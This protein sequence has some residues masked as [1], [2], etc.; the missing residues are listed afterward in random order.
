M[1]D[2]IYRDGWLHSV[3]E[4][5]LIP[6]GIVT[7][8]LE[9]GAEEV[10]IVS[11]FDTLFKRFNKEEIDYD[12]PAVLPTSIAE[13]YKPKEYSA[14]FFS[15]YYPKSG[16][17]NLQPYVDAMIEAGWNT[18]NPSELLQP[19]TDAGFFKM[20][21]DKALFRDD[22]SNRIERVFA[23]T[24]DRT[25]YSSRGYPYET[26][27]LSELEIERVGDLVLADT[28]KINRVHGVRIIF[29]FN[30]V[31]NTMPL[32]L[33]QI[34]YIKRDLVREMADIDAT[35]PHELVLVDGI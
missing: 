12:N 15:R 30:V 34:S 21:I 19:K 22:S 7:P 23:M 33:Y 4:I 5:N 25:G 8:V 6:Y 35:L 17:E 14:S 9:E 16:S 29:G 3:E 26:Y 20:Y 32:N 18:S 13:I 10:E 1:S 2:L 24:V 27:Q 31:D 28:S 11:P